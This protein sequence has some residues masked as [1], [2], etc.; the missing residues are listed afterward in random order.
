[1]SK[2]IF[3]SNRLPVTVKKQETGLIYNESIGG[4][5]T[6]LKSYHQQG[7]SLWAGWPG[8]ASDALAVEDRQTIGKEL[9]KKYQCLPVF[10]SEREIDQYYHGFCNE[11]IWPL[12]HYFT[13]HTQYSQE[14]WEAYKRVNEKF[15]EALIP[16]IGDQDTI[17]IHDYQLMLLPQMIR[18]KYPEARIG[19]FLHIP[20]PSFEIFRLLIWRE[21]ILQ[22]LLGAN[23]IGFHTYDYVRHFVSSV[24]RILGIEHNLYKLNCEIH[25]VRVDA[26]PMG[27]DYDYFNKHRTEQVSA[28]LEAFIE[29]TQEI[30]NIVSIDRLDYTKGIPDRIRAFKRFLE[31][32]PE[33]HERVRLNLIVAPSRVEVETYDRLKREIETLV[34]EVNGRFGTV[35]WMPVWFFFRTFS[36]EDL[37]AFYR[38]SDVLLVTPLR[39]GMNLVA[40]EY[41][42]ARHD[43]K[44]MLV[45]SETAGAASELGEAV[46]VNAND[47]GAIARG[48]KAALDMPEAEIMERNRRMHHRISRY[49]VRFWADEFIHALSS[50]E[51]DAKPSKPLL[52]LTGDSPLEEAYQSAEHRLLFLDYDGTLVGFKATPDQAKPDE[53]LKRLLTELSK[54]T[55][56]KVVII[57]GR[58]RHII[59]KWLGDLNVYIIASHGLWFRKPGDSWVKTINVDDAWK[60]PIRHILEMYT[61]RMPGSLIEEKDYSLAW[62]YRQCEPDT[63]AQKRDELR[64]ALISITQSMSLG[65][66]EGNKVLEVKDARVNKGHGVHLLT[67]NDKYDFILGVGDDHTDEDLFAAL[68]EEAYS[69]KIGSGNTHA[70]YRLKS[71]KEMRVLLRKMV[72]FSK[73]KKF[74]SI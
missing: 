43:F 66:L 25:T 65:V 21:E 7:G 55:A 33:Y 45:M 10:L 53:E 23:L 52:Q 36:Q 71:P 64:E 57:T 51:Q 41:I 39:D 58:D 31:D 27:I 42:A 4:L 70:A 40:K 56:N 54:D 74:A 20:F 8:I 47:H 46:I 48:I 32:Y 13:G 11:T 9:R 30:R 29:S 24:R 73:N 6:G 59:E 72:E 49:H 1:M 69:I 16:V 68:P 12:F 18:E 5:A 61:D 38:H 62:H 3:V 26:F 34:S 44:G 28:E 17:W 2:I 67:R 19:F 14:T 37:I 35:N 60:E 50:A 22:G 63:I 15:F